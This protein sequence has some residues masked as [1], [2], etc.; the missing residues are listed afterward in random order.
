MLIKKQEFCEGLSAGFSSPQSSSF[1]TI[2]RRDRFVPHNDDMGFGIYY[3]PGNNNIL[4][5]FPIIF[6]ILDKSTAKP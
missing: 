2:L 3:I 5:T 6:T 1:L 4:S